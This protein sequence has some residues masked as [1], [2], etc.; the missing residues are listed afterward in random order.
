MMKFDALRLAQVRQELLVGRIWPEAAIQAYQ[1]GHLRNLSANTKGASRA[2]QASSEVPEC[3]S[4]VVGGNAV[5][6]S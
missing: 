4:R 2:S 1:P 5:Y 6:G 3:V